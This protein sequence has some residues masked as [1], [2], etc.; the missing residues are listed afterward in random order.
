MFT[1]PLQLSLEHLYT[2]FHLRNG[3]FLPFLCAAG[4]S[5]VLNPALG[6]ARAA[7]NQ[8]GPTSADSD[9]SVQS[10]QQPHTLL[11]NLLLQLHAFVPIH[12]RCSPAGGE[13]EL[14]RPSDWP[15]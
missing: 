10:T 14:R 3:T 11:S 4:R 12:G 1:Q 15:E 8:P 5:F 13:S 9:G 7:I 6:C 2:C